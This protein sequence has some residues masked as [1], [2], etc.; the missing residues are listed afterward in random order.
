MVPRW[1]HFG[2]LKGCLLI[3][4][5]A[6]ELPKGFQRV[7]VVFLK[8]IEPLVKVDYSL[9]GRSLSTTALQGKGDINDSKAMPRSGENR[10]RAR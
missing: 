10:G 9:L 2:I 3:V 4:C 6:L 5:F 7:P 8:C 1:D